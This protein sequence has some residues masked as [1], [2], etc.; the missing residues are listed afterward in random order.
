VRFGQWNSLVGRVDAVIERVTR[1]YDE[2]L[3]VD[4]AKKRFPPP[5]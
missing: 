3:L 4:N 5:G 1:E 2:I